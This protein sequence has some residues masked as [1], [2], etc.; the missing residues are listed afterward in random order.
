MS[1]KADYTAWL[2][3][4]AK[5]VAEIAREGG[6]LGFGGTLVGDEEQAALKDLASALGVT[7]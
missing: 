4:R 2:F 1:A 6:S 7:A 3:V 5:E